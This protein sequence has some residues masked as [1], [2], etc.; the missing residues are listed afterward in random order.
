MLAI[1]RPVRIGDQV[2]VLAST[3]QV[4]EIDLLYTIL[5][6]GENWHYVPSMVMFSSVIKKKKIL[7]DKA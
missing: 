6:D 2:T 3:G 4:K 7:I 1:T 5:E